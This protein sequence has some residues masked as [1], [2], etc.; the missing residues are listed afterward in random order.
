MPAPTLAWLA[1]QAGRNADR[2]A[3]M[4]AEL[5]A[6]LGAAESADVE[7]MPLKGAVLST[8][9]GADPADGRWRTSTCSSDRGTVSGSREVLVGLGYRHVPDGHRRPT[10]DVF[11]EPGG[12]GRLSTPK[13]STRTIRGGSRSTSRSSATC[14]AG[15]TTTT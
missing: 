3:R 9:P 8:M 6:I 1:E 14:G 11:V 7:V 10:H 5:A 4:H 15:R 13:A 12:G 2:I